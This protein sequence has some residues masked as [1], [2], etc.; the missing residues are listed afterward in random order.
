MV[1][2]RLC[3]AKVPQ[4]NYTDH[5]RRCSS[6]GDGR[7]AAASEPVESTETTRCTICSMR[8]DAKGIASHFRR[9][10]ADRASLEVGAG[11]EAPEAACTAPMRNPGSDVAS[12]A[13][14]SEASAATA[15]CAI[16][17]EHFNAK[18]LSSHSRRCSANRDAAFLRAAAEA[19]DS[20]DTSR[21]GGREA[22]NTA[23]REDNIMGMRRCTICSGHFPS[24]GLSKH[25][26]GCSTAR[27]IYL[28]AVA[29]ATAA[30]QASVGKAA[31][32][33]AAAAAAGAGPQKQQQSPRVAVRPSIEVEDLEYGGDEWH[34]GEQ[35]DAD[36]AEGIM[37]G[38]GAGARVSLGLLGGRVLEHVDQRE[39]VCM[40]AYFAFA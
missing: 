27:D 6:I 18:G 4:N 24:R 10:A 29:A 21:A 3:G 35:D 20:N 11:D 1:C 17:G 8:F 13:G 23:A 16:C 2:C 12:R 38:A 14:G 39:S 28:R 5:F 40:E 33:A 34:W 9:C 15:A 36:E 37:T 32:G 25:F 19:T 7:G 22:S 30:S 31:E 26:K